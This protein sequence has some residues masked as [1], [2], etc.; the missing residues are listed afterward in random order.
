MSCSAVA[1]DGEGDASLLAALSG[2]SVRES[3]QNSIVRHLPLAQT[4]KKTHDNDIDERGEDR[5]SNVEDKGA[6]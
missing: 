2:T 3:Q 1:R 5:M 6:L 4:P